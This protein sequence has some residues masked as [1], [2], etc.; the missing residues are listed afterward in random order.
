MLLARIVTDRVH[1]VAG[2]RESLPIG[3]KPLDFRG[4]RKLEVCATLG[5]FA[6][7]HPLNRTHF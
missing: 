3:I 1:S 4:M 2:G 7:A 6:A 5:G